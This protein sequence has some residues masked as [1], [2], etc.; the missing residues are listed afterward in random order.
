MAALGGEPFPPLPEIPMEGRSW[1]WHP[2]ASVDLPF[3]LKAISMEPDRMVLQ[4]V[5]LELPGWTVVATDGKRMHI[6][7]GTETPGEPEKR[8]LLGKAQV[9]TL[10]KAFGGRREG[11]R[12]FETDT[13]IMVVGEWS[14]SRR[15][16][17]C[18]TAEA[19][20]PDWRT[21]L[22]TAMGMELL[23]EVE[24]PRALLERVAREGRPAVSK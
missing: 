21:V 20:Y 8:L 14:D 12:I 18:R 6:A 9:E 19:Q 2:E 1:P 13:G 10:L 15:L 11:I 16:V 24:L 17:L 22:Q 3:A 4:D 7:H 5:L 23:R